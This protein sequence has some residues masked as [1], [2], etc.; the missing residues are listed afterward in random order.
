MHERVRAVRHADRLRHAE[1]FGRLDA[2]TRAT[3]GPKTNWPSSSTSAKA[4]FSCGNQRCVLRLDVYERDVHGRNES[5]EARLRAFPR[6]R[7]R[8]PRQ[9]RGTCHDRRDDRVVDVVEGVVEVLPLAAERPADPGEGEAP[10]RGAQQRQQR[11]AAERR[12]ED[13][14]RDRHERA[15][16]RSEPAEEDRPVVPAVEPALR[17]VELRLVQVQPAPVALEERTCRRRRRSPSRPSSRACSRSSR[18]GRC[19]DT[20][21]ARAR[22]SSRRAARPGRRTRP[23]RRAPP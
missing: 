21:R 11:V 1:V 16:D 3:F 4:C 12:L 22:A 6:L 10:D 8:L 2:R 5:S 17:P 18:R 7:S 13:A 23:T 9:I 20:P 14:G 15:D 19:R